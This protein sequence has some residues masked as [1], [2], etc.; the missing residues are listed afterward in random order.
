MVRSVERCFNKVL[1]NAR[2]TCDELLTTL[3]EV[4]ATLN[5]RPLTHLYDKVR[6]KPLTPSHL[7]MGRRLL[8]ML[9]DLVDKEESD[10]K[11]CQDRYQFLGM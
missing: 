10:E 2:L 5:S 9:G 3:L 1:G 6:S 8:S 11:Y 7:V 4:K